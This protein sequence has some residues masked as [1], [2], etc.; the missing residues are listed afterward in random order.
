MVAGVTEQDLT[1]RA[2]IRNAAMAEFAE[3]GMAGAS[4][5]GIAGRAGVSAALV[6]HHF[7]TKD[8]L[9]AACDAQV[10]DYLA[11]EAEAGIDRGQ[12]GEAD[13]IARVYATSPLVLR[14]LARALVDGSPGAAQVFE[15]VVE[16]TERYLPNPPDAVA[17]PHTRAVVFAAMRMGVVALHEHVSRALG[18]D[19]L[20]GGTAATR[21]GRATL[22]IVAPSLFPD[23]VRESV[24]DAIDQYERRFEREEGQ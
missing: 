20:T 19:M 21:V 8:G 11:T 3:R 23:G 10:L 6:Q 14:Y 9:R 13:F 22:D 5:R 7:G 17:D 24:R 4:I 1:A 16:L 12:I 18:V 15:R 2:R